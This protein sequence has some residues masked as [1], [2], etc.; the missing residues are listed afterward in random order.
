MKAHLS[1]FL[2]LALATAL[3]SVPCLHL[4]PSGWT[5]STPAQASA[6]VM[7]PPYAGPP[8]GE[9]IAFQ[10]F[11]DRGRPVPLISYP[12]RHPGPDLAPAEQKW[13]AQSGLSRLLIP[14]GPPDHSYVCHDWIF[15]GGH[16]SILGSPIEEIL[17]DNGYEKVELPRMGDLA[18]YRDRNARAIMHTGIV[19]AL[20]RGVLVESKWA[21]M[22]RYVHPA[23]VYGQPYAVCSFYRSA[24]VGHLLHGLDAHP[25]PATP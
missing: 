12:Y 10:A 14:T 19:T 11:T 17:K 3:V 23:H 15:T 7:M 21:W 5:Q 20:D 6:Q 2:A 24:R 9:G 16:Y 13:L 1:R 4:L 8:P 25:T 18:V 22:G